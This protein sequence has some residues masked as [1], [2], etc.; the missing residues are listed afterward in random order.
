MKNARTADSTEPPQQITQIKRV[1]SNS[2]IALRCFHF[3]LMSEPTTAA[4]T[5]LRK[6]R[7]GGKILPQKP[8][9]M[10]ENGMLSDVVSRTPSIAQFSIDN[11]SRRVERE[12]N[13][14]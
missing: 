4:T 6:P 3:E 1:C 12:K 7:A 2:F 14:N 10:W 8:L 5:K 9:F 13:N 11:I